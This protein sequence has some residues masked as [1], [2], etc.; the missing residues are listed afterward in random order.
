M[1]IGGVRVFDGQRMLDAQDVVIRDGVIASVCDETSQSADIDGRGCTL[2]P[3]LFDA[4][5]H[6]SHRR[7]GVCLDDVHGR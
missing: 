6:V 4:H 3:G 1:R 5:V 2:L 7:V